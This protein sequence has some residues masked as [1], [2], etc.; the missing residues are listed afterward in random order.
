M[1][2]SDGW[3]MAPINPRHFQK[4]ENKMKARASVM[5]ALVLICSLLALPAPV[6]ATPP[7]PLTIEAQMWMAGENSAAG[8][9]WTSGLF[10]D[11]GYDFGDASEV[12]FIADDTIHGTKTLVGANGTITL[13]FQAQILWTGEATA[14]VIGRFAVISGTGAYEKLHGVGETYATLDL[15]CMGPDCPPN[16]VATYTGKAHFD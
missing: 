4:R 3:D 9:F 13:K 10:D 6:L 12:F 8:I 14:D 1:I 5:M 7:E 16:I 2:D 11:Y 15:G